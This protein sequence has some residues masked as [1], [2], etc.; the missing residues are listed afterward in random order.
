MAL[1]IER[2]EVAKD[3]NVEL[4]LEKS[5]D[6]TVSADPQQIRQTILN[7]TLNALESSKSGA[8]VRLWVQDCEDGVICGCQD[9]GVG[10]T[11]EQIDRLFDPY[12]TTKSGGAGLGMSIV[13]RIMQTH[14]GTVSVTSQPGQ[15]TEIL[16]HFP[17]KPPS[18]PH[19]KE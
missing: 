12:F 19:E 16:L 4:T 11:P 10:M 2:A 14:G 7:V 3:R 15:G 13:E 17:R 5:E 6:A 1:V 18:P 8:P 9:K